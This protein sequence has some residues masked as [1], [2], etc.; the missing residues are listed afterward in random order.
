MF[1]PISRVDGDTTPR[2]A[3]RLTVLLC[4]LLGLAVTAIWHDLHDLQDTQQRS[5]APASPGV[6]SRPDSSETLKD[7]ESAPVVETL[8]EAAASM[9]AASPASCEVGLFNLATGAQ[10]QTLRRLA[11]D[12]SAHPDE[13]M[14]AGGWLLQSR[15]ATDA[16]ALA[17]AVAEDAS[18]RQA[19]R[20]GLHDTAQYCADTLSRSEAA[21]LQPGAQAVDRLA[22]LAASTRDPVVYALA[23]QACHPSGLTFHAPEADC[24]LL[25]AEQWARLDP[26]NA[27]PW[28]HLALQ[29]GADGDAID[30]A[31]RRAAMATHVEAHAGAL[32]ALVTQAFASGDTRTD[33]VAPEL[34]TAQVPRPDLDAVAL[35]CN[36]AALNDI[37]R[38]SMCDSLAR[39]LVSHARS[40]AE[41]LA[42]VQLGERLGWP[43]DDTNLMTRKLQLRTDSPRRNTAAATSCPRTER[44][45]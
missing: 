33:V 6:E 3:G 43:A 17:A 38:V 10:P 39:L 20:D 18:C 41:V 11:A 28:L 32:A 9:P 24:Q 30:N 27:V 12:L 44:R 21:L 45:P 1:A 40:D 14:R 7:P 4:L 19:Q 42:G 16:H 34:G 2:P 26:N 5:D 8:A 29:A 23:Y 22:R 25:S 31:V 36:I 13:R 35:H 37:S 15:L